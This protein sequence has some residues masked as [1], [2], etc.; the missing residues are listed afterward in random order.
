MIDH[1]NLPVSDLSRSSKF[2]QSTLSPLNMSLLLQDGDA[3]GFGIDNWEFGI[4]S[5][6]NP[7]PNMHVAFVAKTHVQV[8][9]FFS[10]ARKAGGID[11]GKPGLR[12]EYGPCYY[13]AYIIDPD[14]HNIEAVCRTPSND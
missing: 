1:F 14:G 3:I 10:A 4:V 2:Y 12:T 13:S 9:A 8:E 5:A 6:S 7:F 11:N